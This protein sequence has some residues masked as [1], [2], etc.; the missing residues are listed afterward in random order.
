MTLALRA[1]QGSLLNNIH[2]CVDNTTVM[3]VTKKGNTHSDASVQEVSLIDHVYLEEGIEAL[4][5]YVVSL[6]NF[7][8]GISRRRAVFPSDLA[9][10]WN[11]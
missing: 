1:F 8:D 10:G 3:H 6:A 11:L 5:D 7:A 4:W 9:K 2:V